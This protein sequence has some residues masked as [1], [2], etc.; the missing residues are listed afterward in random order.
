MT[1]ITLY[2][3]DPERD[4][5]GVIFLDFEAMREKLCSD[6][7][8]P[9]VYAK[10]YEGAVDTDD[11]EEMYRIFN[12]NKPGGFTGRAMSCSDV[13]AVRRHGAA[14]TEYWYCDAIGFR[15]TEFDER[16]V[17]EPDGDRIRVVM[18]RP[19]RMAFPKEIRTDLESLQK[20]VG[21]MIE[22][23]Y[24][25]DE[26]VCIVCNDEGKINGMMP[27]RAV[28]GKD[29]GI[30]DV[31][32]GPFFVCGCAGPEFGSLSDEQTEKYMKLFDCPERIFSVRGEIKA[33]PFRPMPF[34]ERDR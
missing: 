20:A 12:E 21:G 24:P 5:A 32:Y 16:A 34:T 10:E 15:R 29:G 26:D 8:D 4:T 30:A 13:L 9:S 19:G 14:E 7:P 22:T 11:L 23:Y 17:P 27:N 28:Y 25:F 33:Y 3:V 2:Q 1:D 31:I 6:A 18:C